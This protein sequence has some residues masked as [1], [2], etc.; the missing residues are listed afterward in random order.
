MNVLDI[1]IIV[2]A[3]AAAIGGY[4]L[5]FL[6]RVLSWAG[7]AAGIAIAARLATDLVH[8]M[9][10]SDPRTRL[11]AALAFLLGLAILGWALGLA[12]GSMLHASLTFGPGLRT[13]DRA[14]GAVVGCV[15]VLVAVWLLIPALA[16]TPGWSARAS[17]DSAIVRAIDDYAPKPPRSVEQLARRVSGGSLPDALGRLA[18][19][20]DAGSVPTNFLPAAVSNR[21]VPSVVKVEGRACHDITDGS[22]FVAGPDIVVTNAHVVAGEQ[23]T[24]VDTRDGRTLRALV[25]AF[26]P[27][28]DVAVLRVRGLGLPTLPMTTRVTDGQIDAVFGHPGGG[29]LRQ[30]PARIAQ[31]I[32]AEG[33]DIYG[34]RSTRRHVIVLAADIRPGDSGGPLVDASGRVAGVAF[35]TDRGGAL[36]GYALANA[37]VRPVLANASDV[38]VG[39]GP[40]IQG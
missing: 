16:L 21:V 38:P 32:T 3:V 6:A 28:R 13:V 34:T 8:S 2:A 11:F 9:S 39:T 23:R 27:Q 20:P 1:A 4:Q 19:P 18:S 26:D 15:G 14:A 12:I 22:G 40:C 7:L 31:Q 5:G 33:S 37:E 25:V 35:A 17:R 24:Q 36:I 30:S 29:A 10:A